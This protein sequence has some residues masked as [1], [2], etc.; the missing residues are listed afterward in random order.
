MN[1][2][3]MLEKLINFI[4]NEMYLDLSHDKMYELGNIFSKLKNDPIY[5]DVE[6][7]I[8]QYN[9]K[10]DNDIIAE[11]KSKIRELKLNEL[12]NG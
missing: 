4:E 8:Q 7:D 6:N 9:L 11:L 12:L 1:R 2:I 10:D 5:I 3:E